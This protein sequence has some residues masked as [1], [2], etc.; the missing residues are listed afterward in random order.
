MEGFKEKSEFDSDEES[1]EEGE[2]DDDDQDEEEVPPTKNGTNVKEKDAAPKDVDMPPLP[3][4]LLTPTSNTVKRK[5][6]A[7]KQGTRKIRTS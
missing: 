1:I 4:P 5:M 3:P 2:E 6:I 7:P